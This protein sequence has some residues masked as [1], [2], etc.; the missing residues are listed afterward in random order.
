M[1][2]ILGV[3][4]DKGEKIINLIFYVFYKNPSNHRLSLI[5][6]S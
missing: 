5:V 6:R 2:V 1:K 4:D 3:T